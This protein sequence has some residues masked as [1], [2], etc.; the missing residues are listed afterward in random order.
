MCY[1]RIVPRGVKAF[2]REEGTLGEGILPRYL[3]RAR[4]H[5]CVKETQSE[6]L[7]PK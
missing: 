4:A 3:C 1:L 7:C 2:H 5:L 6:N